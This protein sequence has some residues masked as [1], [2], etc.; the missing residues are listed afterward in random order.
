MVSISKLIVIEN[1][2]ETNYDYNENL[3]IYIIIFFKCI[4]VN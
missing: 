2:I 1:I 4:F 3:L